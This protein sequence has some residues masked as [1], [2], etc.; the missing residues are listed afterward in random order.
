MTSRLRTENNLKVNVSL[1]RKTLSQ[2]KA[3]KKNR[4]IGGQVLTHTK[5]SGTT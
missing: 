5:I 3:D 1:R 4:K 2:G